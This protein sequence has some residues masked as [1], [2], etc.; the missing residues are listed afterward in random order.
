[1]STPAAPDQLPPPATV[2]LVSPGSAARATI[3][4]GRGAACGPAWL[5]DRGTPRQVV[6]VP[7]G[8]LEAGARPTSGGIPILCP[9]PGRLATTTIEFEGRRFDLEPKDKLGRPIHG[10]VHE[11]PWRVTARGAATVTAEYQL[12]REAPDLL[13][14]WPADFR[15]VVTWAL[16]PRSLTCDLHLTAL[17]RMPAALGLHPYFPLPL[18]P[19]GDTAACRLDVPARQWQPQKDWLPSGPILPAERRV[20][21][22]GSV[23]IGSLE[24]DDVFTDLVAQGGIVTSR[25][26]DPAGAIALR[27]EQDAGCGT[28]VLFT[29]PHRRSVCIEPYTCLPGGATFDPARGWRILDAGAELHCRMTLVLEE[30]ASSG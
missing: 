9:Y 15:L 1:M 11:R 7:E 12:S 18:A 27:V 24:Y 29:P 14:R 2:E 4:V 22:P 17:G 10:L 20:A 16:A 26:V 30:H 8:Y 25:Y 21:F 6:W 23:A 5:D 28:I 3:V 19:G 13:S